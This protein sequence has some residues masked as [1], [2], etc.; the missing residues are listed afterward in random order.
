VRTGPRGRL[1]VDRIVDEALAIID[2]EGLSNLTTRNLAR[3]LSVTQPA[4][5]A[6]VAGLD[7]LRAA[8]AARGAAALSGAVATAVAG[9][10][11]DEAVRAMA[12]AYRSYVQRHPDRYLLQL[13]A[14][15]TDA[16]LAATA[17]AAEAVRGVLRSYGLEEHQVVE[18][19]VAFRAAVHGFVHLEAR[20]ALAAR[21]ATPDGHFDFF[22]EL[23]AAGLRA[24]AP[25][26]AS[27]VPV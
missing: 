18:A 10:A 6:H 22:V 13:S 20:D 24:I 7:E 3:R 26:P 1:T 23:F 2:D 25:T 16:Y 19:H 9:L 21:P 14:P 17:T 15:R 12:H 5:Y 4:L 11:G 27:R 8:V